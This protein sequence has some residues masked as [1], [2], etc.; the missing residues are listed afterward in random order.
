MDLR[1]DIYS[2]GCTLYHLLSGKLP[3]DGD[4][5][6]DVML[7][8]I[9]APVPNLKYALPG[10]P[11][12]LARVVMKMMLKQPDAR[13]QSYAEVMA[14]L[15]RRHTVSADFLWDHVKIQRRRTFDVRKVVAE[16][17][18]VSVEARIQFFRF[19]LHAQFASGIEWN[20]HLAV[21]QFQNACR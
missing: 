4:T 1:S 21:V 18:R 12:E 15:R 8:H 5:A 17:V 9:S 3:Y 19:I 20:V 11:E 16:V 10:C 14:D 13:Q 7:K 6:M 2:L